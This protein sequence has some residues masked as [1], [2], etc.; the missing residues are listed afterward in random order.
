M[1]KNAIRAAQFRVSILLLAASVQAQ[2]GLHPQSLGIGLSWVY[3][4]DSVFAATYTGNF[5]RILHLNPTTKEWR[6]LND[7]DFPVGSITTMVMKNRLEGVGLNVSG[8]APWFTSDGWK[9]VTAGTG[10][11]DGIQ[12]IVLTDS[13][14]V[15]HGNLNRSLE[16]SADG[17]TWVASKGGQT[18]SGGGT[19]RNFKNKV[20]LITGGSFHMISTDAGRNFNIVDF[21]PT[22]TTFKSILEFKMF[23]ADSF[24]VITDNKIY[25]SV[26]GGQ[27]W[28]TGT[29]I[30]EG[31]IKA[32][33]RGPQEYLLLTPDNKGHYTKD[34]GAT[35]AEIAG[36]AASS[37]GA[38]WVFIGDDLYVWPEYKSTD[39]G[40]TWKPFFPGFFNAASAGEIFSMDFTN[41]FGMVG[42]ANGRLSVTRDRGR[43]FTQVD[44]IPGKQ[45]VMALKILKDGRIL[46]GDRNGQVFVTADTGKTWEK[47]FTS[48]FSQNALK[49]SVSEDLKTMIL[50]RGGQPAVSVDGGAT[51]AFIEAMGGNLMQTVKPDGTMIGM[52]NREI[53]QI[54]SDK[55]KVRIDSIPFA[56]TPLDIIAVT[57]KIGY[58]LGRVNGA[59]LTPQD[60]RVYRTDDGFKTSTLAGTLKDGSA[61]AARMQIL[62]ADTVIVWSEGRP[63]HQFSFDAGKTWNKDSL[64]VH[65]RYTTFPS[66]KRVYYFNAQEKIYALTG[67]A[68][69]LQIGASGVFNTGIRKALPERPATRRTFYLSFDSRSELLFL[70]NLG[71]GSQDISL[72]DVLGHRV[73]TERGHDLGMPLNV[74]SLRKGMYFLRTQGPNGHISVARFVKN[75]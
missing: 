69:Y 16:Y 59:P 24:L 33:V 34:A 66:L 58:I 68:V 54:F 22:W 21:N 60:L 73:L 4:K 56:F 41:G 50:S 26:D 25:T 39:M 31:S 47:R 35:W 8:G 61:G 42:H 14:Y 15:G 64:D 62:G 51:W 38:N 7:A 36:P 27:K 20:V 11:K 1:F 29:A 53:F 19:L 75:G 65:G 17:Q 32:I 10:A 9:T 5:R 40:V 70:R 52:A 43:S 55:P 6:W 3:D 48:A 46:A 44:S 45:D 30:P 72:Y 49:F 74:A 28:S 13:G 2:T 71:E 23:S 67:S 63:T 18:G 57:D 12:Q 37:G